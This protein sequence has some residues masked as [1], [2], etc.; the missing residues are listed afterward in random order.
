METPTCEPQKLT[1]VCEMAPM[2]IWS[3]ARLRKQAKVLQKA[4]VRSRVA[5]PIA[6]P[7]M[8]CSAMKHSTKRSGYASY[9]KIFMTFRKILMES[10]KARTILYEYVV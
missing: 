7:T 3:Y 1:F 9:M 8:F 4:T 5:Q 6:T 10:I 2:R